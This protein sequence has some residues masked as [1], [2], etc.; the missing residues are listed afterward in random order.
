MHP[1][2]VSP[3]QFRTLANEI[4]EIATQYLQ[5]LDS[6]PIA[7]PTTGKQSLDLFSSPW[8]EQPEGTQALAA[9][10]QI[11]EHTRAQ[12]ARFWGYVLGSA[13]PA[14]AASDLLASVLNQNVTAWRSS[15]AAVII[16]KTVVGWLAQAISC[17]GFQGSLT[18][19]GS[20]ANLMG[21]AMPPTHLV[22]ATPRSRWFTLQPKFICQF[23]RLWLCWELVEIIF[24]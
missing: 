24:G 11:I 9:L 2:E 7:P 15:P 6:R 13:E 4:T 12:N 17:P 1:L 23:R 14:G 5:A 21:L 20:S 10:T 22:C 3:A 19:G 16:E 8:P 18:G